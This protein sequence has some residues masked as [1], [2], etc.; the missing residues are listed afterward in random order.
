MQ[1]ENVKRYLCQP[2]VGR[3]DGW[4]VGILVGGLV[5]VIV[6]NPEG[7]MT[8]AALGPILGILVGDDD[9]TVDGTLEGRTTS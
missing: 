5:G 4:P 6:G 8:G 3:D 1:Y 7:W 9:G 2:P